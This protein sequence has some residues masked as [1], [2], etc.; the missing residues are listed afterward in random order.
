MALKRKRFRIIIIILLFIVYFFMAARP[1]KREVVLEQKWISSLTSSSL[2]GSQADNLLPFVLGSHFGYVDS[3]GVFAVNRV[4]TNDI[5]LGQNMWT[6]YGAMPANIEIK[7]INEETIINIENAGGYPV[8]RDNRVFVLGSENNSL[9]EI[10]ETGEII[11]TYEFGSMLTCID[12]RAGLLLTGSLDGVIEVFSSA[13]ERIFY[14]EPG[15]SRY[16]VILGCAISSDGSRIGIIS[17]IDQ[18]RFLLLER[19][20]NSGGDY[21]VVYHEF[22]DAG[23][24][25][26]VRILFVDDDRR[27][28]YE[29]TG[30]IN[31][32]NMRTRRSVFIPLDGEIIAVEE[33]GEQGFLFLVIS[34]S[35]PESLIEKKLVGVRFP[36]D[37]WFDIS[38][39]SDAIFM[40]ALFKSDDVF[41][42]RTGSSLIA[43][44]GTTL[45]SF[46]LKE[47]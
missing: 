30:G 14:F 10:N 21:K 9:S 1:V 46:E 7:N 34:H 13:G 25:R 4:K 47:K 33:S 6:E 16:A 2:Q 28:V 8:L 12:A 44:G 26:P 15:G 37:R 40:S 23:F 11:W 29:R 5:A 45:V 38:R 17:G 19:F 20:G 18:Q 31:C 22:L 36:Q 39:S 41:L 3:S 24:S 35:S 42:A 43:G 27:I 32:Y